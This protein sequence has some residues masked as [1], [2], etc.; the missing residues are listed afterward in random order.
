MKNLA[1]RKGF[2]WTS[3]YNDGY[4]TPQ[5]LVTYELRSEALL[6]KIDQSVI[7]S[8]QHE[9]SSFSTSYIP[10]SYIATTKD[11]YD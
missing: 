7:D 11:N 8:I 4:Q 2:K 1:H 6:K 3:W 5:Y 9:V 10:T